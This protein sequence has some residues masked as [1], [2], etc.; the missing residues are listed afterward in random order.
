MTTEKLKDSPAFRSLYERLRRATLA[1]INAVD[2]REAKYY[3]NIADELAA[4][5]TGLAGGADY[6]WRM[7]V[8]EEINRGRGK[9]II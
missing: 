5:I 3:A 2:R 8:V 9:K 6:Y 1:E 7:R 4:A